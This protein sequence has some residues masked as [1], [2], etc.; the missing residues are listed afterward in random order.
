ML[1]NFFSFPGIKNNKSTKPNNQ[2]EKFIS[3]IRKLQTFFSMECMRGESMDPASLTFVARALN[4]RP[5]TGTNQNPNEFPQPYSSPTLFLLLL[6]AWSLVQL[7]RALLNSTAE[8]KGLVG[9]AWRRKRFLAAR[10]D[11]A[12][13]YGRTISVLAI[14]VILG[15]QSLELLAFFCGCWTK[16]ADASTKNWRRRRR[17]GL[18]LGL[19]MN[20]ILTG[21]AEFWW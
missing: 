6:W 10:D 13:T 4:L 2:N 9:W 7:V 14:V 1:V 15:S 19:G 20:E 16:L 8:T 18:L 11:A 3:F 17:D 5:L 12:K 21:W